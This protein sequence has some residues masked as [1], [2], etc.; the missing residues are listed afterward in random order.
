MS[1]RRGVKVAKRLGLAGVTGLAL[2]MQVAGA[3]AQST[4]WDSIL[5]NSHWYVPVPQLLAYM[6]PATS[7]ERPIPAGDQTLWALG[8]ATNGAFSGTVSAELALGPLVSPSS[9]TVQGFVTDNGRIRMLFTPTGGGDVTIGVGFMRDRGGV[10]EMEMQMITG[11]SMLVTHWAYMLPYDPATFTPP[12]P[13]VVPTTLSSPQWSWMAGTPWRM[14]SQSIFG[15]NGPAKLVVTDYVNGYFWGKGVTPQAAGSQAFTVLGSV[16]PEGRVLLATLNA[17]RLSSVYG[18]MSGDPKA[19]FIGLR[20]YGFNEDVT[21]AALSLVPNYAF[22]TEAAG[23]RASRGAAQS[24]YGVSGSE[25][26]LTGPLAPVVGLLD[27]MSAPDVARSVRQTLPLFAGATPQALSQAQ[28]GFRAALSARAAF[29]APARGV[30]MTPFGDH[31]RQGAVDGVSGYALKGGGFAGGADLALSPSL[32]IGAA[33]GWARHSITER[34]VADDSLTTDSWSAGLYGVW[35]VAPAL[36]AFGQVDGALLSGDGRRAIGFMGTTASS[37]LSAS[38][39]HAGAGLRRAFEA[40]PAVTLTP[41]LRIDYAALSVGDDR[42]RGAGPLSLQVDSQSLRELTLGAGLAADIRLSDSVKLS[43]HVG[44]AYDALG[45]R[46]RVTASFAGGGA[47]FVV[48]GIEPS[49]WR[50]SGGL[51]VTGRLASG[52]QVSLRYDVAATPRDFVA[53]GATLR[54]LMPF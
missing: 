52:A 49:R 42:E 3:S 23:D 39:F 27:A 5:S 7:F 30:W 47:P 10:P 45:E 28:Q 44:A 19:A 46:N 37:S 24:L 20:E 53:Q 31:A 32:S 9:M 8:T 26:G 48:E 12:S 51:G 22:A 18:A 41:S 21:S 34:N 2:V 25:A 35:R 43:G 54:L 38:A 29:D 1:V 15:A 13:V 17:G 16:T 14:Q 11:S 4:R 50:L 36:E 33:F 6:S 40:A